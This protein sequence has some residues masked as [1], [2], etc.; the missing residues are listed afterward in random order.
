MS[1]IGDAWEEVKDAVVGGIVGG[2]IGGVLGGIVGLIQGGEKLVKNVG[3]SLSHIGGEISKW[4]KSLPPEVQIFIIMAAMFAVAYF[5][6]LPFIFSLGVETS[7]GAFI[8]VFSVTVNFGAGTVATSTVYALAAGAAA[9]AYHSKNGSFGGDG[10]LTLENRYE[11]ETPSSGN[12]QTNSGNSPNGQI[13]TNPQVP[14]DEDEP[15]TSPSPSGETSTVPSTRTRDY[16]NSPEF[17]NTEERFNPEYNDSVFND[18]ANDDVIDSIDASKGTSQINSDS[19]EHPFNSSI[20]P[21]EYSS[22]DDT[23]TDESFEQSEYESISYESFDEDLTSD[24][25]NSPGSINQNTGESQF[26]EREERSYISREEREPIIELS[27]ELSIDDYSPEYDTYDSSI[28][29][30]SD[31]NIN[32]AIGGVSDFDFDNTSLSTENVDKDSRLYSRAKVSSSNS[33]NNYKSN[34]KTRLDNTPPSQ[35]TGEQIANIIAVGAGAIPYWGDYISLGFSVGFFIDDPSIE[36]AIDVGLDL[37]GAVTPAVPA[38]GTI[39]RVQGNIKDTSKLSKESVIDYLYDNFKVPNS[40][41]KQVK[42]GTNTSDFLLISKEGKNKIH[43]DLTNTSPHVNP[44]ID[45]QFERI[46]KRKIYPKGV[47]DLDEVKDI[48]EKEIKS[49]PSITPRYDDLLDRKRKK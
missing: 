11:G 32:I 35:I 1:W 6:G 24:V 3:K 44:H 13:P 49:N 36:N 34:Y 12:E 21:N 33:S 4:W 38:L 23:V 7:K 31:E 48:I 45:L 42:E 20:S 16:V 5:G 41:K 17:I 27:I 18:S 25:E 30:Y 9:N 10:D 19:I 2:V 15:E 40:F 46:G 26:Q 8:T 37:F 14:E 29:V 28:T 39:S 22:L 43:F 47:K